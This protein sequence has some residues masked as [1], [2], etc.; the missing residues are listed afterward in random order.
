[1]SQERRH[2]G[3]KRDMGSGL[4]PQQAQNGMIGLLSREKVNLISRPQIF[5]GHR[6][7]GPYEKEVTSIQSTAE[8]IS[9]FLDVTSLFIISQSHITPKA[10]HTERLYKIEVHCGKTQG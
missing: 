4:I 8:H 2:G 9:T 7:G 10:F 5:K 3:G 1:M 6:N